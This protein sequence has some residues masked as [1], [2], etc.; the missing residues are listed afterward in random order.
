MM[1]ETISV[2]LLGALVACGNAPADDRTQRVELDNGLRVILRPI[3]SANNVALVLLY[4]IGDVHD[5]PGKSG[6]G[7]FIE[8]VYVTAAAG[9]RS[10]ARRRTE[11]RPCQVG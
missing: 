11:P 5:P 7:H 3:E 8:H 4:D 9:G 1:R 6:M 10:R 2:A